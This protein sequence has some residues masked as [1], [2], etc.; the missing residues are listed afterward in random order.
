MNT[1]KNPKL[2]ESLSN[3]LN[4]K[5][6]IIDLMRTLKLF[7]LLKSML[8]GCFLSLVRGNIRKKITDFTTLGMLGKMPIFFKMLT[9][10]EMSPEVLTPKKML[11]NLG[12]MDPSIGLPSTQGFLARM[13]HKDLFCTK[14]LLRFNLAE[15][16]KF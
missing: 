2:P 5:G 11:G 8:N 3:Y 10:L 14:L 12:T 6:L 7:Q 9:R 16:K 4:E 15:L 13:G 1:K